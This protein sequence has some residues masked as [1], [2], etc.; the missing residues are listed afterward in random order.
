[1]RIEE[2][3]FLCLDIYVFKCFPVLKVK[4]LSTVR[5]SFRFETELTAIMAEFYPDSL[6]TDIHISSYYH[7]VRKMPTN[8]SVF[9][10]SST[11]VYVQIKPPGR[12]RLES[13]EVR[14]LSFASI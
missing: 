14:C 10:S 13:R 8:L 4:S 7:A 1:M 11:E 9:V 2:L 5:G 12:H 3:V 6:G